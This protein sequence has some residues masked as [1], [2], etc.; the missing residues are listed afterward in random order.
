MLYELI[1]LKERWEGPSEQTGEFGAK[2]VNRQGP[3]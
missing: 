2:H 1:N 3:E